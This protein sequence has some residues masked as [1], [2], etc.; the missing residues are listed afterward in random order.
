MIW[1]GWVYGILPFEGYSMP[2]HLY[3]YIFNIY[4]YD[5]V[6]LGLWHITLWRLFNA[7]SSLYIYIQYIWV[8]FGLVGFCGISLFEDYSMPNPLYTYIFNI[9][10]YD[11]VW[12]GLW[13]ITLWRL[14]N[15]K[16]SLYIYIQYIRVWFGLVGFMAYH[17]LKVIQC[18][19]I[20]IHIYSIYTS[21]IWFG[22]VLW[23]ITFW[24]LFNAKSSLYIYIQYIRVWF[25]LVR[26]MAYHPLKVIQCQIIFMHI[27]SIYTSM[28]WFG[29]VLWHITLWR[30][31]NTK[32]SLYI[33]NKY[34]WF[35]NEWFVNDIIFKRAWDHVF[36]HC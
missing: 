17:P 25:G 19:I 12:L 35:V 14:F 4:E 8:W 30:L 27:Y 29:W 31:F 20:F 33:L 15:A 6:W 32:S 10:E 3:T 13:H 18:Q 5:L 36:I 9:Y 24:R 23:H 1:F 11:F 26:F 21:M 16:S 2:N 28:I 34:V 22:W 7:K